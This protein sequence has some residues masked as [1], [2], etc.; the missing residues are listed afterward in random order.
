[1]DLHIRDADPS[2]HA[3]VADLIAASYGQYEETFGSYWAPYLADLLDVEGRQADGE[4]IVAELDGALVG[5]VT[6]LPHYRNDAIP[7]GFAGGGC[8]I[9]VLA[10]AP[11]ARGHGVG[12]ALVDECVRRARGL[13]ATSLLLHTGSFM[14]AAV[15]LYE[16]MGFERVANEGDPELDTR[17]LTYR[18]AV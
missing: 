17:L 8:G 4:L 13:G 1:M 3:A 5:S 9:R 2:E 18:L 15:H 10:T 11:A 7:G 16:R 14:E 6:F 12:R